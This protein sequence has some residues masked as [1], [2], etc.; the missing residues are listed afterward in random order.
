MDIYVVCV[1]I[2]YMFMGPHPPLQNRSEIFLMSVPPKVIYR[3]MPQMDRKRGEEIN[4][5]L[6]WE[7]K[8]E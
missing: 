7:E 6:E 1:P 2:P 3:L 5:D 8:A 4:G